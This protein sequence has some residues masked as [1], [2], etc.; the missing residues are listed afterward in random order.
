MAFFGL[1]GNDRQ[2]AGSTYSKRESA[3]DKAS[4]K[5]RENHRRTLT[6]TA[7]QGQ[8]WEDGERQRQDHGGRRS[9]RR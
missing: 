7:R 9:W 2:M 8:A 5:R 3:S 4:R 1:I 6:A